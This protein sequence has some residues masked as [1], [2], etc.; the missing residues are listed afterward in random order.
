MRMLRIKKFIDTARPPH[1]ETPGAAGYD[2]F[3]AE[4]LTLEP[5]ERKA[6]SLGLAIQTPSDCY[7]R[8]APR[9]GLA[10][11]GIDVGGGVV[12]SDYRGEVKVI[13]INCSES[14]FKVAVHDRIA[15]L[16]LERIETPEV[17]I[18]E[19]LGSTARGSNGFGST[20]I[21]HGTE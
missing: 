14:V 12:D 10:L 5:G 8:I 7:G 3:S 16:L 4:E 21:N 2:L 17:E 13:L 1:R 6:C 9:S 20:G 15:Q 11:R 19:E 18:V